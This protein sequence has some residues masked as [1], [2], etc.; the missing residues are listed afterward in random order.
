MVWG[1][2]QF[3]IS[4]FQGSYLCFVLALC[5]YIMPFQTQELEAAEHVLGTL[6]LEM[7]FHHTPMAF[8]SPFLLLFSLSF[9]V[10]VGPVGIASRG[11]VAPGL[12]YHCDVQALF[13]V[14]PLGY[15]RL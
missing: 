7:P 11:P 13:Q 6:G 3:V 9:L 8:P 1:V 10:A 2:R 15:L 12:V 4:G 5:R 14:F